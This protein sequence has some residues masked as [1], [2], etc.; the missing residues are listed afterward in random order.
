MLLVVVGIVLAVGVHPIDDPSLLMSPLA[1]SSRSSVV[2]ALR[3]STRALPMAVLGL[4][5]GAGALVA[6]TARRL[7]RHQLVDRP[8]R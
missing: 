7:S 2:L 4:A 1:E 6:A 8:R 5:L 3:S